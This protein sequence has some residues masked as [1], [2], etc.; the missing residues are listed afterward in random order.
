MFSPF[1][2]GARLAAALMM[3]VLTVVVASAQEKAVLF[4]NVQVFDGKS[5]KLSGPQNVLVRGNKIEKISATPIAVDKS[6][7]TTI[8]NGDKRTLMPGL[9]DNH[10]HTIF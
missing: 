6:A 1:R 2:I 7:N 8:I 4:Q 3:A 9:I 5:D 10:W